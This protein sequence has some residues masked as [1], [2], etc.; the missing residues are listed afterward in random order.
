M[1]ARWLGSHRIDLDEC[2][3]TNDEAG[4]LAR[5]GARHGTVVIALAQRAGRG[6]EGRPWAS[7]PGTGLY[8]SAVVRPPL[9]LADVPPMTLAIGIGVCDAARAMGVPAQL[10][11]PNDALVC[12]GEQQRK[13]AGVLIEAQSQGARLESVV[14]GI[15]VNI[16]PLGPDVPTDVAARAISLEEA[17]GM[18]IDRE[19]FIAT[20]LG[21]VEHWVD[22]Y[23][24]MG[25]ETI[26]PAWTE[27]MAHGL[28][29]RAM[30]DGAPQIG[31]LAGLD[32]DGALLVRMSSGTTHRVRSGD[33]ELVTPHTTDARP[34][35]VAQATC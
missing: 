30:I 17:A 3:S 25:V 13:L 11:W 28:V 16:R 5:A 14:I 26:I 8:L 33:V 1:I 23:I 4:R 34:A 9:P 35:E 24:A 27:R 6:R 2:S 32:S 7:P 21:H 10:K 29:A 31:E 22:R 19:V 18:T 20:L 12:E 15:G